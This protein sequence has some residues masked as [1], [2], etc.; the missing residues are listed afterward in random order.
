MPGANR[1]IR[2]RLLVAL[3]I[4]A[5]AAA[6]YAFVVRSPA[7]GSVFVASHEDASVVGAA[8][9][10][11][12]A[13]FRHGE[14]Q[15]ERLPCLVC[16]KR[17]DNSATPRLSGHVP[18]SSCHV[19]QF[20][21]NNNPICSICHTATDV[22]R[23]PRLKSFGTRFDHARHIKET[24]CATCHKPSR[25]GVALS[26]PTGST[27][28]TA[29][30]QCHGPRTMAGGENIGSCGTCH[31]SGR[32]TRNSDSARAFSFNFSHSE[33]SPKVS[34]SGCHTVR[35]G[36]GRG[37]QVS[38]PVVSMHFAPARSLSCGGCH[39]NVRAFGGDDFKDCK[40][41]HEGRTFKF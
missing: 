30:Y 26:L 21:D 9:P 8:A 11:N 40:R 25:R 4:S 32:P 2:L 22:K 5:S 7:P 14:P 33:H 29:C 41:C 19:Q 24:G 37:R 10:Q 27:A 31:T 13:V 20:A 16:H 34:C 38:S 28:H 17:E 15:H 39:N 1:T 35:A 36:M 23:F 12:Y 3:V 6:G 18:C